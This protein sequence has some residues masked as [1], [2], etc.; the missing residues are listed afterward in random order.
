MILSI[1]IE[2]NSTM[3]QTIEII[4]TDRFFD[5]KCSLFIVFYQVPNEKGYERYNKRDNTKSI[6]SRPGSKMG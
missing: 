2:R 3:L 6:L 4:F 1:F 5:F